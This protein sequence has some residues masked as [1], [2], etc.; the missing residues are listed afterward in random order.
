MSIIGQTYFDKQG[1]AACNHEWHDATTKVGPEWVCAKCKVTYTE[2]KK[3]P[4]TPKREWVGLTDEA[5]QDMATNY[6]ADDWAVRK[7]L[8]LLADHE[9]KLKEKNT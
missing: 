5:K 8:Q 6:F 4:A 3:A 2:S 7:A 1:G 9:A